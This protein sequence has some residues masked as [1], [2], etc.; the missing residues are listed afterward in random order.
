MGL[1]GTLTETLK[2][3]TESPNRG[4]GTEESAGAYWCHD[5]DERLLDLD[6]EG[7][8]APSCPDCGDEMT[9][10]RSPG[11]TGCAC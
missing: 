1:L 9:F 3:S 7:E 10:E 4:D 6:V 5:C 11:S 2:A 8:E